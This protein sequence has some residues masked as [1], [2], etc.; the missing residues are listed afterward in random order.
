MYDEG[1]DGPHEFG[2]T[3]DKLELA[4]VLFMDVVSYSLL[5]IDRQTD[6]IKQLQ[7]IIRSLP[8]F[9]KSLA[10]DQIICSPTGDGMA[11][12]F[13][14]DP[15]TPLL[16]SRMVFLSLKKNPTFELRMGIHSGPIYRVHDINR[17][18]NV[19][20]AGI[21]LAQRVMDCGD[22]GHILVSKAV[23]DI[24]LQLSNWKSVVHDLGEYTVK[25]DVSIHLFNVYDDEVGNREIPF[26]LRPKYRVDSALQTGSDE[27]TSTENPGLLDA[28]SKAAVEILVSFFSGTEGNATKKSGEEIA[29]ELKQRL[30]RHP[31]AKEIIDQ[32]RNSPLDLNIQATAQ[33]EIRKLVR[34][35]SELARL[36]ERFTDGLAGYKTVVN[37]RGGK[38]AIQIGTVA[39]DV[40]LRIGSDRE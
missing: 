26:K 39:G 21:N 22:G 8:D 19:A 3:T 6:V 29:A 20:G 40:N 14:G 9:E 16:W 18:W 30:L 10:A 7:T 36:L 37:I 28:L 12:T 27:V 35:D 31:A 23:A 2:Q 25:H 32:L 15:T 4:H 34:L 33:T 1:T 17:N 24:L 5:E 13:F 38:N 11:L